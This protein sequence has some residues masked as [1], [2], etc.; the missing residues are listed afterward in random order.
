MSDRPESLQGAA[1]EAELAK[2]N[3]EFDTKFE[4]IFKLKEKGYS[5]EKISFAQAA[6]SNMLGELLN[7]PSSQLRTL[8]VL[9]IIFKCL[10]K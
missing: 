9:E 6:M 2:K 10:I 8:K 7:I 1:L 4:E 3:R 5:A